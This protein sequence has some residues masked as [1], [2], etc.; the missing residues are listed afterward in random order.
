VPPSVPRNP[1]SKAFVVA[2]PTGVGKTAFAAD[3]AEEVGGE[4]V[5]CD[6][7][8]ALRGLAVLT[9]QPDPSLLRRVPHHLYGS[10]ALEENLSAAAFAEKVRARIA[11]IESRGMLPLV[12]GGS[13]LYVSAVFGGLDPLPPVDPTIR[14]EVA[15][16]SPAVA[17]E[18]LARADPAAPAALDCRNPRR[19]TRAL[20]IV[21]QT[22][23]P[24]AESR[25]SGGLV[26]LDGIVLLREREE[27]RGRIR[28]NVRAMFERGVEEEVGLAG[29]AGPT[30][31]RAIGFSVIRELL[32][33]RI[34]R[35]EAIEAVW[36][37]T[38]GYARRQLTWFRNRITISS[39]MLSDRP[40]SR[41]ALRAMLVRAR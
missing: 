18:R 29:S 25:R 6:P 15:R 20:E 9:A 11:E 12:V 16:L 3:L 37:A 4:V 1:S 30:A 21:L 38:W 32:H 27:L 36:C 22:G 14:E 40:L 35:E 33:G 34:S 26:D 39:L 24:L 10:L 8:Q 28:A 41:E 13:G 7:F 17:L 2:G 19:V 31:S 5:C 23:R